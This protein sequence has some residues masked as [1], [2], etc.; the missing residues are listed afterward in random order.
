ML[1]GWKRERSEKVSS[2]RLYEEPMA[3]PDGK[4]ESYDVH[5]FPTV[6]SDSPNAMAAASHC[7]HRARERG[8][9]A[10]CQQTVYRRGSALA[11]G[12]A[13]CCTS[14]TV[15]MGELQ[16][17]LVMMMYPTSPLAMVR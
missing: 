3:Q 14:S 9:R 7:S 5:S 15:V 12:R 4:R 6:V 8:V 16:K 17:P 2:D 11:F 13:A 1:V 10:N